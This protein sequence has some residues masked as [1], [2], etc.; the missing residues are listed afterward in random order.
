ML[1]TRLAATSVLAAPTVVLDSGTFIGMASSSA[2]Q[3]F[4]GIP[5]A[6]P[7]E[8][9][10]G[11]RRFRLPTPPSPYTGSH[12]IIAMGPACPQQ[13]IVLP[14]LTGLPQQVTNLIV[15]SG[16][17][18]FFPSSEH[19]FTLNIIKRTTAIVTSKVPVVVWIF[20][21]TNVYYGRLQR[22]EHDNETHH[23]HPIV[24]RSIEMGESVIYVS[25]NYRSSAFGFLASNEARA[26]DVEK[27]G[28]Q[29]QRQALRW[30]QKYITS[31]G[32]D[33]TKVT[34]W[35]LSAGAISVS[36]QMLSNSGDNEGRHATGCS[37]AL[38]TLA[39][40]RTVPYC[41]AES[42]TG[43]IALST[44]RGET[45]SPSYFSYQSLVLAWLPHEDGT[46]LTDNPVRLVE[47]GKVSNVPF[48][49]GDSDDEGT[50]CS[51]SSLNVTADAQFHEYVSSIWL[52]Q[53]KT[54]QV[55][56]LAALY[57]KDIIKGSP[58]DMGE[59]NALSPQFKRISAVQGAYV[60]QAP[61]RFFRHSRSGKQKQWGFRKSDFPFLGSFH[62]FDKLNI[63]SDGELTDYLINFATDL[64][65]NGGTVPN[66]PECA[67]ATPNMMKFFEGLYPMAITQDAYRAEALA[68]LT[69]LTLQ[70]PI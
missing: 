31:F 67:V 53:A 17:A 30:I 39:C 54:A 11:D 37:Q 9:N 16:F 6:L 32:G 24:Q 50:F 41:E 45:T 61:H 34:I 28:L 57:P 14:I 46:F 26:A 8:F 23:H 21:D 70:F 18:A 65:P 13:A 15:N 49:T 20:G 19:C 58:F 59:F 56:S 44:N 22:H 12:T 36:L 25:M 64:D 47:Q 60:F 66:W 62:A 7:P 55:Q 2:T 42:G 38:N 4:L 40:M 27:L 63:Y 69:N 51:L 48:I 3:S 52:P 29:D 35:G 10:T 33:P 68:S 1:H 5:F 43:R